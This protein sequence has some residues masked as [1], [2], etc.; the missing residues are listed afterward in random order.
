MKI[1]IPI[2]PK[3]MD[4]AIKEEIAKWKKE[5]AKLQRKVEALTD[6]KDNYAEEVERL[7]D[8]CSKMQTVYDAVKEIVS[9]FVDIHKLEH[10]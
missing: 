5:N 9:S 10:L 2:D 7:Q 4:K 1:D 8:E 6:M 3:Q